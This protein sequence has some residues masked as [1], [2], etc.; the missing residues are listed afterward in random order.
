M[1]VLVCPCKFKLKTYPAPPQ[2]F[3]TTAIVKVAILNLQSNPEK[4]SPQNFLVLLLGQS[5]YQKIIWSFPQ[6]LE[7]LISTDYGNNQNIVAN[8]LSFLIKLKTKVLNTPNKF[9]YFILK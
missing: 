3:T 5:Y 1:G 2:S 4:I 9:L 7:E 8:N 6:P